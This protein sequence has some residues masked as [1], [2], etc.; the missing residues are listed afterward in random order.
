MI[1][2]DEKM[3]YVSDHKP[4]HSPMGMRRSVQ[5]DTDHLFL[6]HHAKIHFLPP[7]VASATQVGFPGRSARL[8][9]LP[10]FPLPFPLPLPPPG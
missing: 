7:M 5:I 3:R 8:P 10:D 1:A 6:I 4:V 2:V 9:L